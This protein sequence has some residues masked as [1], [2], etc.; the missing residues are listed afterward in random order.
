M[1]GRRLDTLA[2]GLS[3]LRFFNITLVRPIECLAGALE[4]GGKFEGF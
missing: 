4:V 3:L 1:I 2:L